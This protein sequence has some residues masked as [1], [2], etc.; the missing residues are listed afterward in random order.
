MSISVEEARA[1][2]AMTQLGKLRSLGLAILVA[3]AAASCAGTAVELDGPPSRS[4]LARR[5]NPPAEALV[6]E[7]DASPDGFDPSRFSRA[8]ALAR[9]AR[10]LE[11]S[12]ETLSSDGG[13]ICTGSTPPPEYCDALRSKVVELRA[14]ASRAL[15]AC[16]RVSSRVLTR[17][18]AES[19]CSR[20]P[21][22]R[23]L[24]IRPV[25]R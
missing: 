14:M 6:H 22:R 3:G 16:R 2:Y 25:A 15:A 13:Q 9:M 24:V 17:V 10:A 19:L 11:R 4:T 5:G 21:A 23:V 7:E 1:K 8:S 20:R 12:A 18:G